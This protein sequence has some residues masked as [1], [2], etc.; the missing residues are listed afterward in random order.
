MM[1]LARPISAYPTPEYPATVCN[2]IMVWEQKYMEEST[3]L[4]NHELVYDGTGRIIS[5]GALEC[6][7]R[8]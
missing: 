1:L 2:S 4:C 3:V 7:P 6:G 8:G 5:G